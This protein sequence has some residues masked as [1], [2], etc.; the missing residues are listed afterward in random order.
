MATEIQISSNLLDPTT[1]RECLL[2]S[3]PRESTGVDLTTRNR[4][5]RFRSPAPDATVLIALVSSVSATIGVLITGLL[6][7][8]EQRS[9]PGQIVIEGA[10]GWKVVVSTTTPHDKVQE[11]ILLAREVE[12]PRIHLISSEESI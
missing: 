8:L 11:L 2:S 4:V 1:L 7:V 3:F 6:R 5:D 9:L 12:K 10:S